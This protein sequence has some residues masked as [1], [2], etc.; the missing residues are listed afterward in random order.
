MYPFN[1]PL[2]EIFNSLGVPLLI[3]V[4]V[5]HDDEAGVYIATSPNV[6]GLVVEAETLDEVRNEVSLILPDLIEMNYKHMSARKQNNACLEFRT[7]LH[8]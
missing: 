7:P 6:K 3:V 5:E 1:W 4:K 2:A 8:A